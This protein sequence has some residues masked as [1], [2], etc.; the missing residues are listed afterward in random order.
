[1]SIEKIVSIIESILFV[2]GEPVSIKD[3]EES[4]KLD[5][6]SMEKALEMIIF[7]YESDTSGI[8]IKKF[9]G[10]LQLVTKKENYDYIN[11]FFGGDRKKFLSKAAME[12][13]SIIA[14]KQPVTKSEIDN[15][16]GVKSDSIIYRLIREELVEVKGV[17]ERP[18]R[19][20]LYGTTEIFLRNFGI[21]DLKELP[22]VPEIENKDEE[23]K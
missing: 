19:P 21:E 12:T 7:K 16:R 15:I 20:N 18:G 10:K 11:N 14:Y 17:L 6:I 4:L 3:I 23:I 8:D 1:M 13:L 5:K 9:A 2:S 22:E